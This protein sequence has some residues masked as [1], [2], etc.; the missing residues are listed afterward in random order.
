MAQKEILRGTKPIT[1][2]AGGKEA[3]LFIHGY[4][5]SPNDFNG[6]PAFLHEHYGV[7]VFVPLL[8]GH[9]TKVEDLR[10]LTKDDFIKTAEEALK[11]LLVSYDKVI[12][13]GHSFGAQ[14]ALCLAARYKVNGVFVS[15][16][17]FKLRFPLSFPWLY[18]FYQMLP[19]KKEFFRKKISKKERKQRKGSFFYDKMPAYGL[20]LLS[21][22]NKELERS[23]QKIE[24]PLLSIY[25]KGDPIAHPDA[26][27][28]I[29]NLVGSRINK[30][31]MFDRLSHGIFFT[32]D[33]P[34]IY[35]E[36]AQFFNMGL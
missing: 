21:D 30:T 12:I 14:V 2:L 36:I 4:T 25:F 8:P 35:E 34:K 6:L 28:K 5:G 26:R 18:D 13:G 10:G 31:L 23:L 7:S 3:V 16:L 17:P 29:K 33:A 1:L 27:N 24:S 9:G 19:G 22:M 11:P 20:K 15:A 32:E